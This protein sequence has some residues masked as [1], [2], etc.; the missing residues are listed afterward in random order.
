MSRAKGEFDL[1]EWTVVA[2]E[3]VDQAPAWDWSIEREI[4]AKAGAELVAHYCQAQGDVAAA[5]RHSD[6][7]I[8]HVESITAVVLEAA[9]RCRALIQAGVG[10]EG[11]DLEAA[12][13][14]GIAVAN[15]PDYCADEVSDHAMAFL[16]AV[17]RGLRSLDRRVRHGEWD[18][19]VAGPLHRLRGR[20]L[21]LYGFGRIAR[22]VAQKAQGF[23]LRII[24]HDPFIPHAAMV[25]A[26]VE[27]A[28]DFGV[29]LASSDY[30]SL[31]TPLTA[32]NY[33]MFDATTL[34]RMRPDSY[35]IN[36]SRG[37]LVDEDDLLD[38]LRNGH[39][40]GAALD[41]FEDEP[42]PPDHPLF[43]LDNVL[44]T[45]HVAWF[46]VDSLRERSVLSANAVV[47]ALDGRLPPHTLNAQDGFPWLEGEPS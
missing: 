39:L 9:T 37:G 45:P 22:L 41:V 42:P 16:L 32:E 26:G 23:G 18:Y 8:S 40:A 17:A 38:A 36:V 25:E 10:Y 2:L 15:V 21:G 43:A 5:L 12:A 11:V 1:V 34:A 44:V 47:A 4:L 24:A 29:F 14:Q 33:K 19:E 46:S 3:D 27:Q 13:V 20:T 30:L 35:L 31:H 6:A 28:D 7:A